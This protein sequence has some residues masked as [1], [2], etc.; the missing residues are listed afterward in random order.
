[1]TIP[2]L[3]TIRYLRLF[4]AI[5]VV[6]LCVW[7]IKAA[8]S[9]GVS[10]LLSRYAVGL[11]NLSAA[12]KATEV[13]PSD[14]QAHRAHAAV[15]SLVDSDADTAMALEQALA[16]KPS[17]Y[18][19]WLA[20]GTLRDKMGDTSAALAALDEAVKHAPY[21]A[22]TRWQRGNVLLRTGQFEAAFRDL[23]LAVQSNPEFLP[24]LIDLAW[25]LTKGDSQLTQQL[26]E[27]K[28]EKM[29]SFFASYLA[30]KGRPAEVVEQLGQVEVTDG[31]TR[32]E[33]VKQLIERRAFN[34]AYQIWSGGRAPE[35][36]SGAIHD[37]G[38]EGPLNVGEVGFGWRIAKELQAAELSIDPNKPHS[39]ARSLR[40][41]FTGNSLPSASLL[42]QLIMVEPS[43]RYRV[44]FALRAHDFVT[45]GPPIAVILDAAV[46]DA[47][48]AQTPPLSK[49]TA[50]WQVISLEFNTRPETKA[51][52]LSFQRHPCAEYPCPV[53]G[54][55]RLDSVSLER[56]K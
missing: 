8:G 34:E 52:L 1:M 38:F 50:E 15:L 2:K 12:Q 19:A 54:S 49:P 18:S 37:G 32:S 41:D 23:N 22:N 53:F 39:G 45:G 31:S 35:A 3:F 20:L 43:Q 28:S 10:R 51:V 26:V 42:S 5:V 17:D 6:G 36:N 11:R 7:A 33:I 9:Y 55:I 30:R 21:Y 47:V 24:N 48:L 56:L 40:I 25:N 4:C 46:P 16:V 29:R 13:A 14:P 27:V 44:N